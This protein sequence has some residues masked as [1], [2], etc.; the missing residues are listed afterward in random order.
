VLLG[1]HGIYKRNE[2]TID[3]CQIGTRCS[4]CMPN[5]TKCIL[6]VS[7]TM[8]VEV[9]V[10]HGPSACC[11][12]SQVQPLMTISSSHSHLRPEAGFFVKHLQKLQ[13]LADAAG[14]LWPTTS[15]LSF[16]IIKAYHVWLTACFLV[17]RS[18]FFTSLRAPFT[19]TS[20]PGF[21][22]HWR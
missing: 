7:L 21:P 2:D 4:F 15:A 18:H 12:Q 19:W 6:L 8:A 10:A 11:T 3:G 16:S 1:H 5:R 17:T 13:S 20:S 14:K 9:R 22:R